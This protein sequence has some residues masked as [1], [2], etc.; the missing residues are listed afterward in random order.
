[1]TTE[2]STDPVIGD[3]VVTVPVLEREADNMAPVDLPENLFA[4]MLSET[5]GN[6]QANNAQ[7]RAISQM[8][9]GSLLG[10]M[11]RTHNELGVEEARANSAVLATPIAA[12]TTQGS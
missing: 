11:A 4:L 7:G 5:T 1:M 3:G 9:V 2:E 8:A 6:I 12:P 10:G